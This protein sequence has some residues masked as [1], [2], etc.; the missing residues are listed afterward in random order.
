[1]KK[2]DLAYIM[3]GMGAVLAYQRYKKPVKKQMDKIACKMMKKAD[4]MLEDMM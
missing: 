2:M 3:M 1:M 4:N